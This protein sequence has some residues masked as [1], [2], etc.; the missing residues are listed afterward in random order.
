MNNYFVIISFLFWE[1]M[2]L[3]VIPQMDTN[4]KLKL[5][6]YQENKA[7]VSDQLKRRNTCSRIQ[8][9]FKIWGL[10]RKYSFFYLDPCYLPGYPWF[11]PGPIILV[12]VTW[13]PWSVYINVHFTTTILISNSGSTGL[14][15]FQGS[16]KH[17]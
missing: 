5:K 3:R 17:I 10:F 12:P 4:L 15:T 1:I 16:S 11:F 13:W 7:K 8:L 9:S 2:E 6:R 14:G